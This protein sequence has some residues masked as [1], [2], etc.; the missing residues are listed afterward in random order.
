MA[1]VKL[2]DKILEAITYYESRNMEPV[3]AVA[4]NE[5]GLRNLI[6]EIEGYPVDLI[7][8]D[9]VED[10]LGVRVLL[11]KGTN[12]KEFQLFISAV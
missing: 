2:F 6:T 12:A 5:E 7:D 10:L 3:S 8:E 4:L 1:S 9:L 11:S